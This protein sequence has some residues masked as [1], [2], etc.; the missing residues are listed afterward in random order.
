VGDEVTGLPEGILGAVVTPFDVEDA[1]DW[2]ALAQLL[3]FQIEA[4]VHGLF[5]LGTIGEGILLGPDERKAILEFVVERVDGR[6]PVMAHCGAINF[7]VVKDLASHAARLGVEA[8][9]V[10]APFFFRHEEA[11]LSRYYRAVAEAAPDVDVYLYNN[12]E[13]VGYSLS[14]KLVASLVAEVPRI[15]GVKDTGDSV[16]RMVSYLAAAGDVELHVYAGS[17]LVVLPALAVGARGAVSALTN[18]TPHLLVALHRAWSAGRLD[19]ARALQHTIAQLQACLAGMP[20]VAAIKRL[21]S[22]RGLVGGGLRAPL[23]ALDGNRT[24]ELERRVK[25]V[26]ELGLWMSA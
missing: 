19:E 12:P 9:A 2:Q 1:P 18:A 13:R 14:A 24:A 10:V 22:M 3:D 20:Y 21:V 5:V 23:S 17:N 16:A 25:A 4:G 6:V 11:E 8:V 7:R 26:A 15:R